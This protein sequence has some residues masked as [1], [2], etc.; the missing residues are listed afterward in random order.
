[1]SQ[2]SSR[3]TSPHLSIYKPQITSVLSAFHRISGIAA[4]GS[5][6]LMTWWFIFVVFSGFSPLL[7]SLF[8]YTI[9]RL[10][11]FLSSIA[12]FFHL[13]TG[14]RHLLFDIGIGFSIQSINFSA[15]VA[16]AT[17][18]LLSII[19]WLFIV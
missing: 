15:K 5:L 17:F 3:P 13:V 7:L 10:A 14:L 4:F 12:F 1:M 16:I 8:E 2:N 9:F 11:L 6:I 18:V 19:F